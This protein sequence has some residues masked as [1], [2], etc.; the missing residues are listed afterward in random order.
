MN[1]TRMKIGNL[2]RNRWRHA[3][4]Y[5]QVQLNEVRSDEPKDK[6]LYYIFT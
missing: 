3:Y 6:I 5:L 2:C 4:I 1:R